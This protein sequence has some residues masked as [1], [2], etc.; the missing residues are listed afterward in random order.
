M[1]PEQENFDG[2][3]RLLKLKRHEQPPP[4][5]FKDF[6]QQVIAQIKSGATRDEDNLL[7]RLTWQVP[8]LRRLLD[9]FHARPAVAVGFGAAVCVLLVGGIIY[10]ENLGVNPAKPVALVPEPENMATL[11]TP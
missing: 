1:T 9:A 8:W 7:D 10:S 3:R 5:Y 4:R 2:L 11:K 6:S